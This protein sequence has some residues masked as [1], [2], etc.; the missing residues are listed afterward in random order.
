MTRLALAVFIALSIAHTWPFALGLHSHA[1]DYNDAILNIWT[2][3]AIARQLVTDP[4][5]PLNVNM[6]YPFEATLATIDLQLSSGV[7]AAPVTLLSGNPVLGHNLFVFAS[8]VLCGFTTFLLVREL[9]GSVGGAL[10]AGSIYAFAPFR[11]ERLSHSHM[12][13]GFWLPLLLLT[14]HRFVARPRWPTLA[15]A[16]ALFVLQSLA[17]WYYAAI[18]MVAVA[19]VALWSL[20][21][22][23]DWRRV[24]PRGALGAVV[25]FVLLLPFALPYA[26]VSAWE[27]EL[28]GT[29]T[30]EA[31]EH[32]AREGLGARLARLFTRPLDIKGRF[33]LSAEVQ[34]YFGSGPN[35]K[36]WPAVALTRWGSVEGSFFHGVLASVLALIG[37]MA[38]QS[39]ASGKLTHDPSAGIS[40]AS[41]LLGLGLAAIPVLAIVSTAAGAPAVWPVALTRR[42]RL[43]P[44]ACLVLLG[45]S[46]WQTR[47]GRGDPV[48]TSV[49]TYGALAF[50]GILISFGPGVRAFGVD[51]GPG[52]Y[53]GTVPPFS[54]LRVA[55]RFGVLFSLAL[56]VLAGIGFAHV[57]RRL[58]SARGRLLALVAVLLIVN[59]ELR[60]APMRLDPV[61]RISPAYVWLKHADHGAVVEF[62]IHANP[63]VLYGSLFHGKP[64]VNGTGLVVPPPYSTLH[65]RDDLSPAMLDHLRTYFHPRYIVLDPARYQMGEER[66]VFANLAAS[67]SEL[68]LLYQAGTTRVFELLPGG[69]GPRLLRVYPPA[70][71]EGKRG[72]AL[73]GRLEG[74]RPGGERFVYVTVNGRP[75]A[76]FAPEQLRDDQLQF[77]PFREP[78]PDDV[79]VEVAADY[80]LP[81]AARTAPIGQTGVIAPADF[82]MAAETP[83]AWLTINNHDWRGEKG[84]TLVVLDPHSDEVTVRNFNTSWYRSASDEM[85]AFIRSIPAGRIVGLASSYDVSRSLTEEAVSALGTLGFKEDLRDRFLWAHAGVGVKGAA[86]GSAVECVARSAVACGVGKPVP[87]RLELKQLDLY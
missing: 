87:L 64:M 49:R 69:R 10:V 37:V 73:R 53:P 63:W 27:G 16:V 17:S 50:A 79:R 75:G 57:E 51:L 83:Y 48:R 6:Y 12:L 65:S 54:V 80:R 20:A 39:G 13:A 85:A 66:A 35:S 18:A 55:A 77:V 34:H 29:E 2:L 28:L 76:T 86:P 15:A 78:A 25:V 47:R 84:Y 32:A 23:G 41:L 24:L 67:A 74:N 31:A 1:S 5:H 62:P 7:L 9:T 21:A 43:I 70:L 60:V 71:I 58:T 36:G 61:P 59:Q 33:K 44:L 45:W 19:I 82:L 40:R 68:K 30:H 8:F 81:A 46:L 42:L 22:A 14:V 3:G 26:R 56:A 38:A 72:V 4:L 52:V 11:T